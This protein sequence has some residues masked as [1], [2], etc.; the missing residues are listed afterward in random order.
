MRGWP[1]HRWWV[2][3]AVAVATTL[4]I[5]VPTALV[6]T[7]V[8]GR[9]VAAPW[10]AWPVLLVTAALSGL[11]TATYVRMPGTGS[12]GT[13][14]GEGPGGRDPASRRGAVGG[15]LTYLAVGCPTCNKIALLALG[16]SGA[17]RWFAPVQPLLAVAGIALLGYALRRRLIGE[18]RC[19]LPVR[20]LPR[21]LSARL[22]RPARRRT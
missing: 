20:D 18:R 16:S 9:G 3:F 8:F 10:W 15:F 22:P 5:A 6:P 13:E 7:G 1:A 11:I 17:V 14:G 19:D 21:P 2:A 4:L 12:D